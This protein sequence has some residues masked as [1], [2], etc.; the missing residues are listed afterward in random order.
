MDATVNLTTKLSDYAER[1]PAAQVTV[2]TNR[3]GLRLLVGML[4]VL[5]AALTAG[6]IG[7]VTQIAAPDIRG[8]LAIS[9]DQGTWISTF[10]QA[11]QVAT[12]AFAPW[13]AVTF[14]LRRV[15]LVAIVAMTLLGVLC[16]FAPN[17]SS[18]LLLRA[19]QGIAAGSLPPMLMTVALRFLPPHYKLFGLAGYAVTATFGPNLGIPLAALWINYF[20]WQWV[21]WQVVPLGLLS[22]A[23]VAY[24]LPADPLRLER[25]R[26]FDWLGLAT[27]FP[28]LCAL[29]VALLQNDRLDG[30]NS[31]LICLLTVAGLGLLVVFFIN[32][33]FHSLPFFSLGILRRRNFTH[34]LIT[35]AG[36]LIVLSASMVVPAHYLTTTHDYRP[37]QTAPL[38]LLVASTQLVLLPLVAAFCNRRRVDSRWVLAIGLGLCLLSCVDGMSI[39]AAWTRQNFYGLVALQ[40]IA[41]PMI[42]V[43]LLLSSTAVVVPQEGPVAAAWFNTVKAFAAVLGTGVVTALTTSRSDFHNNVLVDQLGDHPLAQ[44]LIHHQTTSASQWLARQIATQAHVMAAADIYAVMAVLTGV[45]LLLVPIL[46]KRVFPP[47]SSVSTTLK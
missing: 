30:F 46:P 14:S 6:L 47:C 32:E 45:L 25:F 3:F 27:G 21:F 4:G 20:H 29:T 11:T 37:L 33:G 19:L 17:A 15:T 36:T 23:A 42:V 1:H 24:G 5:L 16:P 26:Q 34:A 2:S 7:S 18:L 43:A 40:A 13:F 8:A 39:T 44:A 41:E 12:M 35:L 22:Y 38:P 10:Y 9:L 28:A 31:P